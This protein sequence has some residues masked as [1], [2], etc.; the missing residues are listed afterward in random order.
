MFITYIF[1]R[2][3]INK[4]CELVRDSL[5]T[6]FACTSNEIKFQTPDTYQL[7]FIKTKK[8]FVWILE[9][10]IK[11]TNQHTEFNIIFV[12]KYI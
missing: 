10:N 5:K 7:K 12:I 8:K 1:L 3:N 11:Y 6:R 9:E 2:F 4:N